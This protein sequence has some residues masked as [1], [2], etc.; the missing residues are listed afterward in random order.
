MQSSNV[1]FVVFI[2]DGSCSFFCGDSGRAGLIFHFW[3]SK[4]WWFLDFGEYGRNQKYHMTN[5]YADQSDKFLPTQAIK[6]YQN[7]IVFQF[8]FLWE[9]KKHKSHS[10]TQFAN[11]PFTLGRCWWKFWVRRRNSGIRAAGFVYSRGSFNCQTR[12]RESQTK[13]ARVHPPPHYGIKMESLLKF[14]IWTHSMLCEHVNS[15]HDIFWQKV[16]A[17]WKSVQFLHPRPWDRVQSPCCGRTVGS[18]DNSQPGESSWI[19][20]WN[21]RELD[22]NLLS[23]FS[24]FELFRKISL[25]CHPQKSA[26]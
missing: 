3:F 9:N 23:C 7:E 22:F 8:Y 24:A 26:N 5:K 4:N 6:K 13:P 12:L 25:C 19:P 20:S 16:V 1:V 14:R 10:F 18:Q 2:L 17:G 11:Q 21:C 15:E